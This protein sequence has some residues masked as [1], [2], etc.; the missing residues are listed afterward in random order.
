MTPSNQQIEEV[1]PFRLPYQNHHV[2]MHS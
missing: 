2:E 1:A